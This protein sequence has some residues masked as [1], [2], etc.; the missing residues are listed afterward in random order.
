MATATENAAPVELRTEQEENA[1]VVEAEA[2][3]E[4]LVHTTD[5]TPAEAPAESEEVQDIDNG[6]LYKRGP[7]PLRLWKHRYFAFHPDPIP[8]AQLRLVSKKYTK[9]VS[10][11]KEEFEK[12]NRSLFH[13]IASA[14]VSGE[15]LLFYYKSSNPDHVEVP[16][17]ILNLSDIESVA[18]TKTS[19]PHSFLIKTNARE[20][21]LAAPTSDEAKSWVQSIQGKL[22]SL[23]TLTN[24]AESQQ[25][26]DTYEAL[27]SRQAFNPKTTPPIPTGILSDTE[28]LSGSDNENEHRSGESQAAEVQKE[29]VTAPQEDAVAEETPAIAEVS[30]EVQSDSPK[31]KSMFGNFKSFINKKADKPAD[32]AAHSPE[33]ATQAEAENATEAQQE[34]QEAAAPETAEEHAETAES[35][36]ADAKKDEHPSRP[37]SFHLPKFFKAPKKEEKHEAVAE[38]HEEATTEQHA[39]DAANTEVAEGAHAVTGAEAE[40]AE[41]P[42]AVPDHSAEPAR[43]SSP[44]KRTLSNFLH[45]KK[46]KQPEHA[47]DVDVHPPAAE[48]GN[49]EKPLDIVD[50]SKVDAETTTAAPADAASPEPTPEVAAEEPAPIEE[51][52]D[53]PKKQT[54]FKRLSLMVRSNTASKEAAPTSTEAAAPA[55]TQ[56]SEEPIL[57]T[58]QEQPATEEAVKAI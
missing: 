25:Y 22:D 24:P 2:P 29:D 58:P 13:S 18:P 17:G 8:L 38:V 4:E 16:L 28:V 10:A 46:N 6:F 37:L 5:A 49:L 55:T 52:A 43:P 44:F 34:V 48:A 30:S 20:Y 32:A 19:R 26:K 42:D 56:L 40:A 53:K 12:V 7:R 15:G 23:S 51:A 54:L 50:N 27:V 21:T 36:A 45:L 35:P 41:T 14:T 1:P 9:A 57:E 39:E 3:A 31:R 11:N 33:A 47:A